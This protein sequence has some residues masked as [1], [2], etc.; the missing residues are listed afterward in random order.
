MLIEMPKKSPGFGA[1]AAAAESPE[2][3]YYFKILTT[4]DFE[5][6][7]RKRGIYVALVEALPETPVMTLPVPLWHEP[8]KPLPEV[9]PWPEPPEV[10]PP[11]VI[12]LMTLPVP[13]W[14]EPPE[15]L[16]DVLPWPVAP[17][18]TPPETPPWLRI[19][20]PEFEP[21]P[22]I[23]PRAITPG[24]TPWVPRPDEGLPEI[25]GA[26][27]I[28][29]IRTI[30]APLIPFTLPG[31]E[32]FP[33]VMTPPDILRYPETPVV[34]LPGEP[35]VSP[36]IVPWLPRLPYLTEPEI[37]KTYTPP[38]AEEDLL[39]LTPTEVPEAKA[40]SKAPLIAA[41]AILVWASL[42]SGKKRKG[43]G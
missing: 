20:L 24:I 28:P 21:L 26:R 10:I 33:D 2:E 6:E 36:V 34:V 4:G 9:V 14:V 39:P 31:V 29:P 38:Y 5:R 15:A 7:I 16:P 35:G 12:P 11:E 42:T 17:E 25:T 32:P 43:G 40:P 8:D 22:D 1:L 18:V 41:A 13:L 3:F 19:T 37:F 23:L 27:R 30:V